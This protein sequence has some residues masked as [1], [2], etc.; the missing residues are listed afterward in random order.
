MSFIFCFQ[1]NIALI[2]CL[3]N[4]GLRQRHWNQMSSVI[5][6]D[7]TPNSGSSLRK[8]LKMELHVHMSKLQTISLAAT[9]EH[10]LENDLK[11]MKSGW[12]SIQFQVTSV[13]YGLVMSTSNYKIIYGNYFRNSSAKILSSLDTILCYLED[14]LLKTRNIR[15]SPYFKAFESK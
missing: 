3:C 7:V 6:F 1:E 8:V 4:P 13:R 10:S 14:D 9:R 15:G 5:G 11:Q 2:K 12:R